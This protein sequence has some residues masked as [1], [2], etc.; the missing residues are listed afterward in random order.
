MLCAD[1]YRGLDLH[2][3]AREYYGA[4]D[5]AKVGEAVTL[6]GLK[7]G[8]VDDEICIADGCSEFGDDLR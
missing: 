3:F 6:V 8:A 1:A 4:G 5:S 7:L 2:G